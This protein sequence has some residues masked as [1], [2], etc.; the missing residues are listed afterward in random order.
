MRDLFEIIEP[1]NPVEAARRGARPIL[2]RRFY[3]KATAATTAEGHLVQLDDKPVHTPRRRLLAAP[4]LGL[5]Q[6][7]AAEWEAQRD[8]IDPAKMPLTRLANAI[9]DGVAEF[10]GPGG[11]GDRKISRIRSR[12]LPR[13][14]S[15]GAARPP[16]AALGPDPGLGARCARCAIQARR[17]CHSRRPAGR[18]TQG[19]KRR[20]PGRSVAARRGTCGDD[21]DRLGADRARDRAR[22]V[23]SRG[24]MA[25]GSRRRRLEYG[26]MG[27]G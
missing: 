19:C 16:S 4:K 10:V 25:G 5:A 7:I 20:D 26:A 6:A 12:V 11:G 21:T 27:Q 9:I 2:P 22:R 13:P 18:S 1:T 8:L 14:R 3:A 15:G 24:G 17:G 23:G